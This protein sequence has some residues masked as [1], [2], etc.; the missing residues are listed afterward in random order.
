[1]FHHHMG[2]GVM[3]RAEVDRLMERTDPEVVHLLLDTGHLFW[4]ADDPLAMTKAYASR[5]KHVDLK[6][7]RREV[8]ETCNRT[9]R[10]FG[11]AVM[12]GVFTEPGDPEGAI[13]FAPIFQVLAEAGYGGWLLVGAEQDA[14]KA[15]PLD[16]ARM[17]RA[18]L[19]EAAG[20]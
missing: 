12:A 10:T 8:M 9:H 15:N 11:D 1:M 20:L 13:D 19:R 7:I 14:K 6:N 17:A 18:N 3:I 4:A 16:Y 2:T 5:V